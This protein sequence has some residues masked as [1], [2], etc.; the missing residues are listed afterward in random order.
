MEQFS[1]LVVKIKDL[2]ASGLFLCCKLKVFE[3]VQ[4]AYYLLLAFRVSE[5][6][7]EE[8]SGIS[9]GNGKDKF[10]FG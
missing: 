6:K 4:R 7:R 5:V 10:S 3:N 9:H 1:I 2:M 8:D